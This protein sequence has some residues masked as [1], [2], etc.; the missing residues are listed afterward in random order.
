MFKSKIN[1]SSKFPFISHISLYK[2]THFLVVITTHSNTYGCNIIWNKK[3][4]ITQFFSSW[5]S[6]RN[7]NIWFWLQIKESMNCIHIRY[8]KEYRSHNNI[9]MHRLI[10]TEPTEYMN[11]IFAL[12]KSVFLSEHIQYMMKQFEQ[13]MSIIIFSIC[14]TCIQTTQT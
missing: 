7:N 9:N 13:D 5:S 4:L 3:I 12:M 6:S 2:H 10:P 8:T 11:E 14:Y 1:I